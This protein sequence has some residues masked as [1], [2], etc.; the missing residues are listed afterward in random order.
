MH[1]DDKMQNSFM[2][3]KSDFDFG[4][5]EIND[6]TNKPILKPAKP[7]KPIKKFIG[8]KPSGPWKEQGSPRSEFSTSN[9]ILT[10]S[11]DHGL[12]SGSTSAR[13]PI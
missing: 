2:S 4:E 13:S 9:I 12:K 7:P 11:M 1:S 3:K 6:I 10:T 5:T 8:D